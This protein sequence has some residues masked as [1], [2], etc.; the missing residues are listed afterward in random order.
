[1]YNLYTTREL[2]YT[3][4][5][6]KQQ[7]RLSSVARTTQKPTKVF[8]LLF[9]A[10]PKLIQYF[11]VVA[12]NFFFIGNLNVGLHE[13]SRG[14][15]GENQRCSGALEME[16]LR[17]GDVCQYLLSV[18]FFR[19]PPSEAVQM[20]PGKQGV[21]RRDTLILNKDRCSFDQHW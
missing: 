21:A 8:L 19:F 13:E 9:R 3:Y 12:N 6:G 20:K 5:L 18:S 7:Q 1:M 4:F 16:M 17:V 15:G 10:I 14:G 11:F 2:H